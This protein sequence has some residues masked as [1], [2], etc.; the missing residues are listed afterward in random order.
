M[1]SNTKMVLIPLDRYEILTK[2]DKS[3]L[4]MENQNEIGVNKNESDEL[5]EQD[6]LS[7]MP[8]ESKHRAKMVLRHMK[9]NHI[10]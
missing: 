2:K 3:K 9:F 8:E 5:S 7:F 4:E 1:S 6:V 10:L